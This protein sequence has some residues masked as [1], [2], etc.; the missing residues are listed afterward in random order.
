MRLPI[1]RHAGQIAREA[2]PGSKGYL[3]DARQRFVFAV[4]DRFVSRLLVV[5]ALAS[6]ASSATGAMLAVLAPGHL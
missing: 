3:S 1:P 4:S 6:L 2:R 5:Q